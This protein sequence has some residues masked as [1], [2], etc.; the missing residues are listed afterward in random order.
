MGYDACAFCFSPAMYGITEI[1]VASFTRNAVSTR[2]AD[3]SYYYNLEGRLRGL[4]GGQNE[5]RSLLIGFYY[6]L[7]SMTA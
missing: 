1:K 7:T 5:T 3:P 4:F 2:N 6:V